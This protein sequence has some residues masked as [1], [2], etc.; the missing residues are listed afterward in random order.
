MSLPAP[1][2]PNRRYPLLTSGRLV[3]LIDRHEA[4]ARHAWGTAY[5]LPLGTADRARWARTAARHEAHVATLRGALAGRGS[6]ILPRPRTE[7][8]M[9]ASPAPATV[10]A[11]RVAR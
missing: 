1:A 4:N 11:T 9:T 8:L 10:D 2:R 3:A 7:P 6:E 5:G